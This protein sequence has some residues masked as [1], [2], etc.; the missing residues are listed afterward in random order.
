MDSLENRTTE[1][2]RRVDNFGAEN[3][4]AIAV[5]QIAVQKFA[6][7]NG[8]VTEL[9]NTGERRSAAGE[10]KFSRSARRKMLRAELKRD[11]TA[12]IEVAEDIERN[13]PSFDNVF[14]QSRNNRNDATLLETARAVYTAS[15]PPDIEKL[16]TAYGLPAVFRE[17]LRDDTDAFEAAISEQDAANRSRIDANATID[18]TLEQSLDAIR[19]LKIIV[20][21]IFA[22]NP[23]KLAD[24]AAAC[25]IERPS[26]N[27]TPLVS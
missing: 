23:G 1:M 21:K 3:A 2:A 17:D 27:K 25:H 18:N 5:N 10:T 12:I 8:F 4:A 13:N 20:P 14:H 15:E 16:F 26:K 9:E 7:V 19:T 24:W 22:D 11:L 6:V